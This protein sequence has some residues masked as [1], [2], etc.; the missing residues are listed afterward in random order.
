MLRAARI[1]LVAGVLA[2]C[3]GVPA[4]RARR[5]FALRAGATAP[6]RRSRR[7][8]PAA[9]RR[10]RAVHRLRPVRRRPRVRGGSGRHPGRRRRGSI[11][12]DAA[13]VGVSFWASSD[14]GRS[15]PLSL[16]TGVLTGGGDSDVEVGADGSV[17]V[18]DLQAV[19]TAICTSH[20]HGLALPDCDNGHRLERGGPRQRPAMDRARREGR[21]LPD[22]PRL[23]PGLPDH[24]EVDRRRADLHAL[25]HDHRPTGPAAASYLYSRSTR[26][27]KPTI[28]ADG[29]IYV[30]FVTPAG[31]GRAA[32]RVLE[33]VH[34]RR[35]GRA[36]TR[37]RS[38]PT[39]SS[40]PPPEPTW[41]SSSPSR[42][43]TA[44]AASTS[45]ERAC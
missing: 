39:T 2:L 27:T 21:D 45:R 30:A 24:R 20:D 40:T 33:R 38:S 19:A 8:E 25:R 11:D 5:G 7:R 1:A 35:E 17:L 37:R 26:V 10:R 31:R 28:G 14:G 4:V 12:P 15:F 34:G 23:R 22:L 41:A 43:S 13:G 36:A 42:R 16:I 29:S 3:A 9:V 18:A 32:G 44:A 6:A